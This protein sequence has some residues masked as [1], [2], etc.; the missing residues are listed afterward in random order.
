[1]RVAVVGCGVIA[2]AYVKTMAAY[3]QLELVGAYD[4][5]P[6]RARQVLGRRGHVYRSL[7]EVLADDGVDAVLNLTVQHA[8][9]AVVRACLEA[10]KHVHT[11]KP[12]APTYVEAR[13]LAELAERA[14]RR[15]S[16]APINVL[17]EAQQTFWKVVREARL[18]E[19]RVA[20]AEVNWGRIE[21]WHPAPEPF[22]DVGPV[23]DVGVYP[24][25]LLAVV[26]GRFARVSAF[27]RVVEPRRTT[28]AGE[29][30]T[31]TTP[32]FVVALAE[33]ESGP[34]VRLTSTFYADKLKQRGLELH[35]D[36]ASLYIDSWENFD[37][38]LELAVRGG[39]YEP[40]ELVRPGYP[41][42]DWA[43]SLAELDAAVAEGR[44][45]RP[46]AELA[47]HVIE[48]MESI[49]RSAATGQ[50]VVLESRFD[51]PPPMPWA[52]GM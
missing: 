9:P 18:G 15:L 16:C 52:Q 47:A 27:A 1:V 21:S 7:E 25:T 28:R 37:S 30:F 10:G 40:V 43:R 3:P 6:E 41:G 33:L 31:V 34:V 8:H 38:R 4:L 12:L 45:H 22:Y 50:P 23:Y 19:V 32:D 39:A 44:P 2:P 46:S 11:E 13:E 48:V 5:L 51:P 29:P 26:F 24:L 49:H 42:K 35:G 17:G 20:Y 14:G 36:A